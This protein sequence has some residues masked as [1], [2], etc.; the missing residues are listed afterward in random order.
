MKDDS[1]FLK[2][3]QFQIF[4]FNFREWQEWVETLDLDTLEIVGHLGII[5]CSF[6]KDLKFDAFFDDYINA[7]AF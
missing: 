3:I 1:A 4:F 6:Q 5:F 2:Y 7:S